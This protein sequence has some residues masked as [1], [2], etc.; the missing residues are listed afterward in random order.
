ME[1]TVP[2]GGTNLSLLREENVIGRIWLRMEITCLVTCAV[3]DPAESI[4][5]LDCRRALKWTFLRHPNYAELQ[6]G[7]IF[8]VW[9]RNCR[10]Q[11]TDEYTSGNVPRWPCIM[12]AHRPAV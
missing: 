6:P 3:Y 8:G 2:V 5:A 1:R 9:C 10:K 7:K 11:F 4:D 12:S